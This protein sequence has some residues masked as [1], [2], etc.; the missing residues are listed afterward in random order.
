MPRTACVTALVLGLLAALTATQS[1]PSSNSC[2]L[3]NY[4]GIAC[5]DP[6]SE[7]CCNGTIFSLM[8]R[9][10]PSPR[11]SRQSCCQAAD[12]TAYVASSCP[13]LYRPPTT[14]NATA[15]PIQ[16]ILVPP[17][18]IAI[19]SNASS[20][21][22]GSSTN[23]TTNTTVL[24][25]LMSQPATSVPAPSTT[26][27]DNSSSTPTT[28]PSTETTTVAPGPMRLAVTTKAPTP[29]V[30]PNAAASPSG[31]LTWSVAMIAVA[32]LVA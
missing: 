5:M 19:S 18:V 28:A 10:A 23:G 21:N 32:L 15:P 9:Q 29:T 13:I 2:N 31:I 24:P 7:G 16:V 25:P 3:T 22:G 27:T 17:F 30:M 20:R 8:A 14:L 6:A 1:M 26:A 11:M 4:C 12:G